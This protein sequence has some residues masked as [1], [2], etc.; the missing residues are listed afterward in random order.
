MLTLD[1][2]AVRS[3]AKKPTAIVFEEDTK[4]LNIGPKGAPHKG[5]S[6][7]LEDYMRLFDCDKDGD[8]VLFE[9]FKV[10]YARANDYDQKT[11]ICAVARFYE[12][13]CEFEP[14][15]V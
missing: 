1:A 5:L 11:L 4:V 8:E 15:E 13:V 14:T 2:P 7:K 6:A 12:A 3:S 10:L 9:V